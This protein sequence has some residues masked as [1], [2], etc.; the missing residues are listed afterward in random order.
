MD[1]TNYDYNRILFMTADCE[2]N[3][4]VRVMSLQNN[5]Q[6]RKFMSEKPCIVVGRILNASFTCLASGR[7]DVAFSSTKGPSSVVVVPGFLIITNLL[8][9]L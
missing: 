8:L 5:N 3:R 7:L 2:K 9:S 6:R 4:G 1:I